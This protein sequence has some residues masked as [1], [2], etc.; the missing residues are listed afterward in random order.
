MSEIQERVWAAIDKNRLKRLG[1]DMVNIPSPTGQEKDIAHFICDY[2]KELGLIP[3]LQE[4]ETETAP[5]KVDHR[6]VAAFAHE[7]C[8]VA[9][10]NP[11]TVEANAHTSGV[12]LEIDPVVRKFVK[13][14]FA[15][16]HGS[17]L[18]DNRAEPVGS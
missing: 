14:R 12:G 10:G 9:V 3:R 13:E 4:F 16:G 6:I 8:L 5:W 15:L 2:Y 17:D 18:T 7:Q 11:F 1:M